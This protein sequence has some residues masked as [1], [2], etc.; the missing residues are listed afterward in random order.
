MPMVQKIFPT[1]R[2]SVLVLLSLSTSSFFVSSFLHLSP[3]H[4]RNYLIHHNQ[5]RQ[6]SSLQSTENANLIENEIEERSSTVTDVSTVITHF[7]SCFLVATLF[8]TWEG[9]DCTYLKPLSSTIR[10]FPQISKSSS[11]ASDSPQNIVE[12]MAQSTRGMGRGKVDRSDGWYQD[13]YLTS[14]ESISSDIN[15]ARSIP[16]YNEIMLEHR[17]ARVPSWK[18][19]QI[20][21][22]DVENAVD[23]ILSSIET[24]NELK[25]KAN[26]YEW[27]EMKSVLISPVLTSDLQYSCSLLQQ[28]KEFLSDDARQEVGFD[29]GSCAWRRCGAQADAQESLAELYNSIGLFEP[30]ECLFTIDIVERSLR[31]IITVVP[32]DLKPDTTSIIERIGEYVPYEPR[33]G[34]VDGE[35]ETI[36]QDYLDALAK[37]QVYDEDDDGEE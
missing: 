31:D 17:T 13:T 25:L 36:D 35:D 24:L 23:T 3:A 8:I 12:L 15:S 1:R 32:N 33:N 14:R 5:I 22:E 28:A 11:L 7:L 6:R 19:G 16:S 9:I 34:G 27:D 29:W 10:N 2:L 20:A 26:E 4:Q 21:K 37:F 18:L 30:F